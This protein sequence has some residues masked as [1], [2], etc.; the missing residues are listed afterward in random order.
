MNDT[1]KQRVITEMTN[2]AADRSHPLH[3]WAVKWLARFDRAAAAGET[4]QAWQDY[5][6]EVRQMADDLVAAFEP[7]RSTFLAWSE[8]VVAGLGRIG[9]QIKINTG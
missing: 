3:A 1:S 6:T 7:I 2:I 8:A 4:E 9:E 5:A